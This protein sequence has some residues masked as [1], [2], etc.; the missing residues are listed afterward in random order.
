[1]FCSNVSTAVT[2]LRC[3]EK[4][5]KHRNKK[6]NVINILSFCINHGLLTQ[7]VNF[8][9]RDKYAVWYCRMACPLSCSVFHCCSILYRYDFEYQKLSY[10]RETARQ[11][12]KWRGGGVHHTPLRPL[13]LHLCVRSNPKATTY[14]Y[15]KCAVHLAHFKMNRAF[16]VIQGHP[17]WCR[18]ESRTVCSLCCRNVQLMPT[19]FLK[20]AKIRQRE[21]S[22]FV[23]FND[24]TQVWRRPSTKRLRTSTNDLYCQKLE[25]LTY[26]SVA[27]SMGLHSLIFT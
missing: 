24:P 2:N 1:M 25:L 8:V 23:H 14:I 17:Y 11:L 22:K 16:K 9:P 12:P 3:W 4:K 7:L 27:D 19:L 10:R 21:H 15:V 20:L 26:I 18:Q 13:W 6:V 5:M